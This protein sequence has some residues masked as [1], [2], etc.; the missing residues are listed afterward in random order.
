MSINPYHVQYHIDE[1]LMVECLM[2]NYKIIQITG[3]V[4]FA[5][6]VLLEQWNREKTY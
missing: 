3:H 5:G 1:G 6:N 2:S 4:D